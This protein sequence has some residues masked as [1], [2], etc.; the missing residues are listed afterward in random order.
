MSSSLNTNLV[1]V[2]QA[3]E[4][5]VE[6]LGRRFSE[7][8]ISADEL[9]RRLERVEQARSLDA[10]AVVTDDLLDPGTALVP[11]AAPAP[12]AHLPVPVSSSVPEQRTLTAV[13]G[14][15]RVEGAWTVPRHV[16]VYVA[17]GSTVIDLRGATLGP[18]VTTIRVNVVMGGVEIIA[19]PGLPIEAAALV[20]FAGV[21][22]DREVV[23]TS[24]IVDASAPRVR[25]EGMLLFAGLT[26]K[27]RLPGESGRAAR[28][29]H[30]RGRKK[31]L[32][33]A[34]QRMLDEG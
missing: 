14:E 10:I 6:L 11:V 26:I 7:D 27:E 31:A 22:R 24:T 28:K 25:V 20:L 30:K 17:C 29:R 3:R 13:F 1:A 33:E 23:D 34:Q 15:N 12:A 21:D 18:G 2:R 8:L 32:G 19:P 16:D 9:E 4:K 5:A